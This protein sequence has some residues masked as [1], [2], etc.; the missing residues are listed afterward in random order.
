MAKTSGLLKKGAPPA[1]DATTNVIDANPRPDEGKA[2]PLQVR[3]PPSVFTEFSREAND[4][5][6]N[7]IGAK[8]K[9]FLEMWEVYQRH[10]T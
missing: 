6:D 3:V 8:S 1:R 2:Q 4:R 5:F 10:K 9:L 7:R